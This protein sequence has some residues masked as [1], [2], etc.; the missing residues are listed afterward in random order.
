MIDHI[1]DFHPCFRIVE[2]HSEMAIDSFSE[3]VMQ[4]AELENDNALVL[5]VPPNP[6]M[7]VSMWG[8]SGDAEE[9]QVIF[10]YNTE[11][12]TMTAYNACT[13]CT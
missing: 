13:A 11:Q 12:G 4:G 10:N 1:P 2:E 5:V 6:I 9:V 7:G 3:Y 8:P